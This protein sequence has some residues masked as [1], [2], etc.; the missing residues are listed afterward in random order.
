MLHYIKGVIT[1]TMPGMV[2]IENNGI[3]Y[4]VHVPETSRAYL[5]QEGEVITLYTAM[6]VREDDI[7]LYGFT[8]R[9]ALGMF[10]LLQT[11][12][13]VGAKA[14]MAILSALSLRDLKRAIAFEDV[15]AITKANG[16]GKKTAQMVVVKLKDKVGDVSDLD[17][18]EGAPMPSLVPGSNK[19]EA[20]S[21]LM[22]LGFS[23]SEA[24]ASLTG[25][26]DEGLT[27][28]EYIKLALRN[29]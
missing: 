8:E 22:A 7:S 2:C 29:R 27:T 3:G 9:E 25:V 15:G 18:P 13:G 17:L 24:M 28:Q 11:V 10:R 4:E 5:T 6:M 26:T 12:Q 20:V 16:V 1:E 23:K 21:A 19:D 14:A